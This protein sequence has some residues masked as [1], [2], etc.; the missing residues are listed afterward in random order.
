MT[1]VDP[2]AGQLVTVG[3]Q[4]VTVRTVVVYTVEVVSSVVEVS[5]ELELEP[6]TGWVPE[7]VTGT[8]EVVMT[9]ELLV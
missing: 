8:L 1:V 3:A 2:S 7:V 5:T 6:E 9:I 4:D